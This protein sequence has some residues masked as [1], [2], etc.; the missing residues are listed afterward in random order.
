MFLDIS[1]FQKKSTEKYF[2]WFLIL[3]FPWR[4]EDL[5]KSVESYEEKFK[6]VFQQIKDTY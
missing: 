6:N 1:L 4:K 5:L 2:H 3:Y